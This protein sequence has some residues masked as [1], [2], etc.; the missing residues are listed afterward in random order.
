VDIEILGFSGG[1]DG[2]EFTCNA[3]TR[4]RSLAGEDVQDSDTTDS[5]SLFHEEN[6]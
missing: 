6:A 2:K 1:S 3:E 5:L 4:V